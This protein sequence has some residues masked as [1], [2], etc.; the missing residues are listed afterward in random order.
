MTD[1]GRL[2]D[3]YVAAI[4]HNL[5]D[6]SGD[7]RLVGVVRRQMPWFQG[8]VDENREALAPPAGLL[9]EFKQRCEELEDEGRSESEAHNQAW[10]DVGFED[11]YHRYLEETPAAQEAVT[12]LEELLAQGENVVL[13][14]YEN[15][16]EKRCHRILLKEAI[17]QR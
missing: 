8:Q 3:T 14:C 4:Q 2:R 17:Q 5:V 10:N 15:T 7:E 11:R 12:D 13:V 16:D 1:R 6:L 9:D